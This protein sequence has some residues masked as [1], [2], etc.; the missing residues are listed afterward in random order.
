V[1]KCSPRGCYQGEKRYL[2]RSRSLS[3]RSQMAAKFESCGQSEQTG[4]QNWPSKNIAQ[5]SKCSQFVNSGEPSQDRLWVTSRLCGCLVE[6][7]R[8]FRH[9][10]GREPTVDCGL[11]T[12]LAR[13]GCCPA[14]RSNARH[15]SG[16]GPAASRPLELADNRHLLSGQ[17]SRYAGP[18]SGAGLL[19]DESR[20]LDSP[21]ST[22]QP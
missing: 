4:R 21:G 22:S 17:S 3:A 14:S 18:I 19:Q 7:R 5:W 15:L 16:D 10:V 20:P 2:L 12:A 13:P 6:A 8:G 9:P 11:R 1:E